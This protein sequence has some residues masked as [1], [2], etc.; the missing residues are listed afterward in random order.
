MLAGLSRSEW[1]VRRAFMV[2]SST[3]ELFDEFRLRSMI[4]LHPT[5]IG[6]EALFAVMDW[7]LSMTNIGEDRATVAQVSLD[8]F[9]L[10]QVI[11]QG[12]R[13]TVA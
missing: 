9:L 8:R 12:Q 7:L 10:G 2:L 13:D 3:P 6:S 4:I 11:G 1:S 5:F